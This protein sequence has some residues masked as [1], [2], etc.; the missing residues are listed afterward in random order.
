MKKLLKSAGCAGVLVA[1]LTGCANGVAKIP[2]SAFGDTDHYALGLKTKYS[3]KDYLSTY[4]SC[5]DDACRLTA[6]NRFV[7]ELLFLIDYNYNIHTGNI[8]A[9]MAKG[10]FGVGITDTLLS[11]AATVSTV[12]TAKTAYAA[13]ATAVGTGKTQFDKAY[14]A[15]KTTAA[16]ITQMDALRAAAR[17]PLQAGLKTTKY[18]N[19][20]LSRAMRDLNNYYRAGTMANA[21][22]SIGNTAAANAKEIEES[23]D[24]KI[25]E[26]RK[27]LE[28]V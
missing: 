28:G 26:Q 5:Q 7:N 27:L 8:I 16:I 12:E 14:Y 25:E 3:D 11:L 24:E 15:E 10:E 23:S 6:R 4:N 19:Y 1:M 21:I 17:I 2:E 18:T 20:P 13:L 22:V 9:G